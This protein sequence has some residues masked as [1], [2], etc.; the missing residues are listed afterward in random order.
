MTDLPSHGRPKLRI[1]VS[2]L[3]IN[4]KLCRLL[5]FCEAQRRGVAHSGRVETAGGFCEGAAKS[6]VGA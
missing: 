4:T 1:R 5:S 2:S 6:A 3:L